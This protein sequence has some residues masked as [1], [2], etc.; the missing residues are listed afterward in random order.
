MSKPKRKEQRALR[1]GMGGP[2]IGNLVVNQLNKQG[3]LGS[4]KLKIEMPK[5]AV[6]NT[7]VI[8]N[9]PA[10][11]QEC[12]ESFDKEEWILSLQNMDYYNDRALEEDFK[13]PWF[14]YPKFSHQ[15]SEQVFLTPEMCKELLKHMPLNRDVTKSLVEKYMRDIENNRWI[16]TD[17]AFSVDK[18]G[19][20]NNGMHRSLAIVNLEKGWPFYFTWNVPAESIYVKDSGKKRN[21]NDKL[22]ILFPEEKINQKS[23]ALCRCLMWGIT[24][25]AISYSESEIAEFAC[26][27]KSMINWV[28]KK[29][30]NSR[31]D[32]QAAV[33]KSL[34]WWGEEAIEPFVDRFMNI[35]F[36]A[37]DDPAKTLYLWV[38]R[39]RS[40]GRRTSYV[41][42]I[43]Y[44]KKTLT[45]IV[46]DV[47]KKGLKRLD[48]RSEDIF[49]WLPG[50]EVPQTSPCKGHVFK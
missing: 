49:E 39:V 33:G 38:Q 3:I 19:H 6:H 9:W 41:N 14:F 1:G 48:Q 22:A 15:Y 28:G 30:K 47:N 50:W 7:T 17:E 8:Q 20:F 23:A 27:H 35:Q 24:G 43:V 45:A 2:T 31:A 11:W 36:K 10:H 13:K 37:D 16:Q 46:A 29:M 5:P 32:L 12:P 21:I 34:L 42:P 26:K 25:R 18:Y 40:E 4:E 44:Y